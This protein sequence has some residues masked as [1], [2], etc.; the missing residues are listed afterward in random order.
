MKIHSVS[1]VS[2]GLFALT[3][4]STLP[5]APLSSKFTVISAYTAAYNDRDVEAMAELMHPDIQ[6]LSVNGDKVDVFANG[7]ADLVAQMTDYVSSPAATT[8]SLGD[9][10][11]DG[12]YLAVQETAR[13][14]R[15]D[16][17]MGE[18][19]ALAVYEV[20]DGLIRR[21][22]YYPATRDAQ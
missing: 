21:V 7:K 22:W 16:G 15:S 11:T 14:P 17:S 8:S 5:P 3:A 10:V 6:W 19:S 12:P 18:Q 20:S 13:W 1:A 9:I 4:C 2:L